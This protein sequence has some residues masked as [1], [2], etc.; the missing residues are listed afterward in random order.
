MRCPCIVSHTI[1][2]NI[3]CSALAN[4]SY[5]NEMGRPSSYKPEYCEQ[6]YRLSLLGLNDKEMAVFLGV[7]ETCLNNWKLKYPEFIESIKN[8]KE[9]A[10]GKVV[11]SLYKRACGIEKTF[12]VVKYKNGEPYELENTTY[13]PPDTGAIV[14][15]LCNRTHGKWRNY[16]N[17]DGQEP[18]NRDPKELKALAAAMDALT[19][20]PG[21]E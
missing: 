6:V 3:S 16:Q 11:Q 8:G 4:E 15:W 1:P 12:T 5:A 14:F 10:D 7:T 21:A 20:P 19:I 18:S 17:K 13:Y 2:S 9:I